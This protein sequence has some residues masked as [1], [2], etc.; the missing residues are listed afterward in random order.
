[1]AA[2]LAMTFVA[3][4]SLESRAQQ[5]VVRLTVTQAGWSN[6][7]DGPFGGPP[8]IYWRIFID[9]NLRTNES[10]AIESNFSPFSPD[11]E[12]SQS[13]DFSSSP[14]GIEITQWDNDGGFTFGDDQCDISPV[15]EDIDLI[16]DLA[17]CTVSGELSGNCGET[18][19]S[20][21][22]SFQFRIEVDEPPSAPGLQGTCIHSPLWPQEGDTVTITANSLDGTLSPRLADSIEIWVDDQTAPA[23]SAMG[24]TSNFTTSSRSSPSFTYGCRIMD[25]GLT[26]WTGWRTV[27]VGDALAGMYGGRIPVLYTGPRS[28]RIDLVFYADR[29]SYSSSSDPVFLGD[30]ANA[31]SNAYFTED[32]FL[33]N[34][35]AMNYWLAQATGKADPDCDIEAPQ[36]AWEDAGAVFHTDTFRDCAPGGERVFS[37]EPTSLRTMLHETGHRPFGLA[38]EYCCDGG[39]FQN[40]PFPNLFDVLSGSPFILGCAEDAASRGLTAADCRTFDEDV[41]WW[42][43]DDWYTTDPAS[44]DLMVDNQARQPLDDRRI[45]WLFSECRGA[46]C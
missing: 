43:D 15:G 9:G 21:V 10:S 20:G 33:D 5:V 23:S 44:N 41:P 3:V 14:I 45:D 22:G 17:A 46:A 27:A 18:I 42:F 11:R 28:S 16:L 35:D 6:C 2:L 40:N 7:D 39:Y 4:V 36:R 8:E 13:V 30:V 25:D 26:I 12:F 31:I 19:S 24:F 38:D 34:Q 29:D 37:T 32:V 1:M